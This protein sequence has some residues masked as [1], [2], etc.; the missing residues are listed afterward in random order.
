LLLLNQEMKSTMK[1]ILMT[2]AGAVVTCVT[3]LGQTDSFTFDVNQ[4]I[5]DGSPVGLT[6]TTNLSGLDG[7]ISSLTVSLDIEGG[8]NGDLYA[9]LAGPGSG[10]AVLLNRVGVGGDD[11][12][13]YADSGFD[14][15]FSDDAPEN[16]HFYQNTDYSLSGGQLTGTWQPDGRNIDPESLPNNFDL[17]S[18]TALLSS[19]NGMN[20]NGTWT[21]FLT[22]LS[23]GG[24][25]TVVNWGLN[26]T[27]LAVPEPPASAIAFCGGIFLMAVVLYRRKLERRAVAGRN[28]LMPDA[29][30]RSY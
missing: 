23:G 16:V 7:A 6:L 21:L 9:Y 27:M 20:A 26:I 11:S 17:A 22:D 18:A 19:F 3:A 30:R 2:L 12:F 24:Q 5:P 25:S 4:T 8:Y 29:G 14:V 15:E 10:F 1:K 13:G 28:E